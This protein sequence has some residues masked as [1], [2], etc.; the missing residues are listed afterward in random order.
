MF[1]QIIFLLVGDLVIRRAEPFAQQFGDMA[2][3]GLMARAPGHGADEFGK[4]VTSP[5]HRFIMLRGWLHRSA[6]S[7]FDASGNG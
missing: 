4:L 5:G 3:E 7:G 6:E 2:A 1:G